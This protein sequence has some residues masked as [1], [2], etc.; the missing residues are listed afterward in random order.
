MNRVGILLAAGAGRRF[1]G[2]KLL[3]ELDGMSLVAH[4]AAAMQCAVLTAR[5]AVVAAPDVAAVLPDGWQIVTVPPGGDMA[6][7]L[8]A[9]LAAA[10]DWDRLLI[11]LGDMPRV[12]AAHLDAVMAAT[13]D[14]RA[15]ASQI[16]GQAMPPACFPPALRDHLGAVTGDR[17]ARDLIAGLPPAALVAAAPGMLADIDRPADLPGQ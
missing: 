13:R 7:S 15:S 12:T 11:A 9:G 1:G 6:T 4:A 14:D 16:D 5:I 8:R 3:A 10:G 17:G 2:Q